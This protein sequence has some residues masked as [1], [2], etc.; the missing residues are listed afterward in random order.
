L[1]DKVYN[2]TPWL[3]KVREN[4]LR[5]L[6]LSLQNSIKGLIKTSSDSVRKVYLEEGQHFQHLLWSVNLT[7]LFR[8]L[9]ANRHNDSV[10]KFVCAS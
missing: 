6:Q 8:T 10:A 9:L 7:S 4:I 3:E 1:K 5:K 2:S